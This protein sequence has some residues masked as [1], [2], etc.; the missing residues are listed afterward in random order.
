MGQNDVRGERHQFRSVFT[1]G[2]GIPAT[3][4]VVDPDVLADRPPQLLQTLRKRRE[5]GLRLWI[6]GLPGHQHT[7]APHPFGLLRARR[8]RARCRAAEQRDERAPPHSVPS[9]ASARSLS[10]TAKASAFAVFILIT[11]SNLTAC[12]TGRSAGFVP[13][14]ILAA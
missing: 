6:V 3:P 7:D 11:S 10:G 14:R 9:S 13:R 2:I 8:E 4:A 1:R 5:A 12:I